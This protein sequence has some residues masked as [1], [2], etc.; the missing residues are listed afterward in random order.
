MNVSLLYVELNFIKFLDNDSAPTFY[1]L[2]TEVKVKC[3][4]VPVLN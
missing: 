2:D 4:D 1:S 3:K